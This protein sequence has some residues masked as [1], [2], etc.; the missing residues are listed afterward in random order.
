MLK[1][2]VLKKLMVKSCQGF[3]SFIFMEKK[4]SVLKPFFRWDNRPHAKLV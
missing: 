3:S 1:P 2:L 4:I